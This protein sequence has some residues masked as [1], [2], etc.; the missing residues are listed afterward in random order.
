MFYHAATMIKLHILT[1]LFNCNKYVFIVTRY[2]SVYSLSCVDFHEKGLIYFVNTKLKAYKTM[3][4]PPYDKYQINNCEND[5]NRNR[6][7]RQNLVGG[8]LKQN[9]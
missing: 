4:P 8:V 1:H 7:N 9:T 3:I 6:Y 5:K 2:F